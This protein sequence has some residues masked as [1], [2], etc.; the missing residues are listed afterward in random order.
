VRG[1]RHPL[2]GT[3]SMDNI[4]IDLG[5]DTDVQPGE[6]AVLIGA[7]GGE[8]ILAEELARRIDTINYEI[9]CGLSARVR[10]HHNHP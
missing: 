1:R 8:R 10:R 5:P 7:Q 2:V 6:P 3:V 9:T 4:A